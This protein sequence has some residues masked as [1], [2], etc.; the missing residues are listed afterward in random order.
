MFNTDTT[1]GLSYFRPGSLQPLY[2]FELFGLLVALALYNGITIPVNF[3]RALYNHL[4]GL[5]CTELND[6]HDGWPE[7]KRSLQSIKDGAYEGLDYEFPLEANGLRMSINKKGI[8]R[9]RKQCDDY[10]VGKR[11]TMDLDVDEMSRIDA[12]SGSTKS[13]QPSDHEW[14]GWSI[15]APT[16]KATDSQ[17]NAPKPSPWPP[18][19]AAEDEDDHMGLSVDLLAQQ[20]IPGSSFKRLM[21]DIASGRATG[22]QRSDFQNQLNGM[23]ATVQNRPAKTKSKPPPP[24]PPRPSQELTPTLLPAYIK[25]HIAWLITFSVYPQLTSFAKG[26]HTLL[27][28]H[29]LAL[30]TPTTLSRTLSGTSTLDLPTL[31]SATQYKDYTASDP[32]ILSF[33]RILASWSQEDQKALLRFV[34]A[35]ERLPISGAQGLTFKIQRSFVLLQENLNDVGDVEALPTSSTCFGTLYLPKYRDEETLERKLRVALE[36]G[37]V[38]FGTA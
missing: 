6:I 21:E 14:P 10:A 5:Q 26:F 20:M 27:P 16:S 31:R 11:S 8:D 13:Y 23:S 9:V 32:Y 36:F 30:F 37:G 12:P 34:T 24:P 15:H 33:W 38:G 25:D 19:S 22:A 3:P 7:I 17:N 28:R 29:H 18:T 4:L 35:A 1:T 2:M